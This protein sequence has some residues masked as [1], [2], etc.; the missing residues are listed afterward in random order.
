[1]S[2]HCVNLRTRQQTPLFSKT[3][4][5]GDFEKG[6]YPIYGLLTIG[7]MVINHH[8]FMRI[9][10]L[11][12]KSN[13][14]VFVFFPF[15]YLL[16][17]PFSLHCAALNFI[18]TF[19]QF[20]PIIFSMIFATFQCSHFSCWMALCDWGP[21]RVCFQGLFGI[22]LGL[23]WFLMVGFVYLGSVLELGLGLILGWFWIW[24][25]QG[26]FRFM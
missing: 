25:M 14:S 17:W 24:S 13:N 8:I 3:Q 4:R 11:I 18:A 26:W 9:P 5:M 10:R 2:K 20:K 1:M 21:C 7:N 23:V 12:S 15:L 19:L 16:F 22:D 6:V